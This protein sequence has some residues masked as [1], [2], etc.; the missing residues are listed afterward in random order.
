MEKENYYTTGPRLPLAIRIL[1]IY[2]KNF[3]SL[4]PALSTWV[5]WKLFTTP[6]RREIRHK[7]KS[8]LKTANSEI[9]NIEN[10]SI[11]T[12]TWGNG[13]KKILIV[14]GWEGFSA[15]FEE[16]IISLIDNGFRVMS[17]DLPA[18]G[19]SSGKFTHLP[20]LINVVKKIVVEQGPFYGIVSHSLG[21]TVSALT[22]ARINGASNL[23]KL[24]LMGLQPVPFAFFKQF[25]MALRIEDKLFDKCVLYVENKVDIKIKETSVDKIAS[26]ISAN[27]VLLVH[28]EN[29]EVAHINNV[30]K[31]N[32]EWGKSELFF[33]NHGGHFKHYKHPEVVKKVVQFLAD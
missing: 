17:V 10:H 4:F 9:L 2:Y 28:D 27:N 33:G 29:D 19:S 14:H 6:K 25:R 15:D 20:M 21:A 12:Y 24:I 7:H 1:K 8:F 3:G 23:S 30:R 18:H 22:S 26:L 32:K 5:F 16:I 31:L 11:Q 13:S